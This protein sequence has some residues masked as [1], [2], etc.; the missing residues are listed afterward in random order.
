MGARAERPSAHALYLAAWAS[1]TA[2]F[3][4]QWLGTWL[5]GRVLTRHAQG[6]GSNHQPSKNQNQM[7]FFFFKFLNVCWPTRLELMKSDSFSAS[8]LRKSRERYVSQLLDES[9]KFF[10]HFIYLLLFCVY[11]YFF[12]QCV[13]GCQIPLSGI[14]PQ[15][16]GRALN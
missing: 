8:P 1:F 2:L 5:S 3:L 16:S 15:S 11:W 12:L 10:S 14:E 7:R 4:L 6:P 13:W 9:N